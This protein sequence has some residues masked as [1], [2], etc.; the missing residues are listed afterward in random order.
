MYRISSSSLLYLSYNSFMLVSD[1]YELPSTNKSN[2]VVLSTSRHL[3]TIV[4]TSS[5][6]NESGI[7]NRQYFADFSGT[8]SLNDGDLINCIGSFPGC[9]PIMIFCLSG[10]SVGEDTPLEAMM[11]GMFALIDIAEL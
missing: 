7:I 2:A 11:Y 4:R 3:L 6:Q 10:A 8:G 9:S 1:V 5:M